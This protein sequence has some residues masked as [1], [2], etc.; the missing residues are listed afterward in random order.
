M[1]LNSSFLKLIYIWVK[2]IQ[3]QKWYGNF[4]ILGAG[5]LKSDETL[6]ISLPKLYFL[7]KISDEDFLDEI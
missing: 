7:D 1:K 6:E 2:S 3:I 5:D 4:W